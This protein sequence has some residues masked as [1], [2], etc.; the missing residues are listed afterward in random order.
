MRSLFFPSRFPPVG[1][2]SM[3]KFP[4]TA[5]SSFSLY[6]VQEFRPGLLP[7]LKSLPRVIPPPWFPMFR[8]KK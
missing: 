2:E 3:D 6:K 4:Q 1:V 7:S 8:K 5:T